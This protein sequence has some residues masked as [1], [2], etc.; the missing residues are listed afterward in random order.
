[1]RIKKDKLTIQDIENDLKSFLMLSDFSSA[2]GLSILIDTV[3]DLRIILRTNDHPMPHFH[4]ESRQRG[5]NAT[6]SI[7][8]LELLKIKNGRISTKDL[9]NIERYFNLNPEKKEFLKSEYNR[10]NN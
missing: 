1:M 8:A 10:A 7:E 2:Q 3:G 9:R 4:I 6:F 5:I